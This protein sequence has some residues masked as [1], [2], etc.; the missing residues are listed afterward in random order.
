MIGKQ[1]CSHCWSIWLILQKMRIHLL[2]SK[3]DF[4]SCDGEVSVMR[5]FSECT[6]SIILHVLTGRLPKKLENPL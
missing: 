4:V 6:G 5:Y 3:L 1:Y 2:L